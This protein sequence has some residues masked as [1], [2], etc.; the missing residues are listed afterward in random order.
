MVVEGQ[1]G[2]RVAHVPPNGINACSFPLLIEIRA[3]ERQEGQWDPGD[4]GDGQG[5]LWSR[6]SRRNC[7][8]PRFL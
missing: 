7:S 2:P 5:R 4:G 6:V 1:M 8:F 3:L